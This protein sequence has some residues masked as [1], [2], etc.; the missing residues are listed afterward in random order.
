MRIDS[1]IR[2]LHVARYGATDDVESYFGT[3]GST[4]P[5][6][7]DEPGENHRMLA[8]SCVCGHH[9]VSMEGVV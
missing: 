1:R 3:L 9:P 7:D 5:L 4:R 8:Q 6:R 2:Q